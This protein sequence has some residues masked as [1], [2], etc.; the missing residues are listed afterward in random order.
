MADATDL[1][2][3][4]PKGSCGFESRHRH[5]VPEPLRRR[6]AVVRITNNSKNHRT[7][8]RRYEGSVAL[9][10]PVQAVK[11]ARIGCQGPWPGHLRAC[12]HSGR[13]IYLCYTKEGHP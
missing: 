2:S 5:Q 4:D 10:L 13:C 12:A 7:L 11:R 1:K 3:V 6:L 9:S 8:A